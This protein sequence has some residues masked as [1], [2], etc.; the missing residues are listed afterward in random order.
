MVLLIFICLLPA[1]LKR[2]ALRASVHVVLKIV[3]I[4]LA[5]FAAIAFGVCA[6]EHPWGCPGLSLPA[7]SQTTSESNL[8]K[9]A[10]SLYLNPE[11]CRPD[12]DLPVVFHFFAFSIIKTRVASISLL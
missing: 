11:L 12:Y 3:P 6:A 8:R 1:Y 9:P 7:H 4:P 2:R 10:A 5:E